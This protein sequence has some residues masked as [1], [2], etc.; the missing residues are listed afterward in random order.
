MRGISLLGSF[1]VDCAE[2]WTLALYWTCMKK[3]LVPKEPMYNILLSITDMTSQIGL[4]FRCLVC[5]WG[6][7]S[8]LQWQLQRIS[9]IMKEAGFSGFIYEAQHYQVD[10][11]QSW[12]SHCLWHGTNGDKQ[13][14]QTNE[15]SFHDSF[16]TSSNNRVCIAKPWFSVRCFGH[17]CSQQFVWTCNHLRNF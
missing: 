17:C 3:A 12:E 11:G 1:I 6:D 2:S 13:Q 9:R 5:S 16:C 14:E 4:C 10:S 15:S 7:I 8:R